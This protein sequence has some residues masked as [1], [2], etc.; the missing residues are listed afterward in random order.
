MNITRLERRVKLYSHLTIIYFLIAAIFLYFINGSVSIAYFIILIVTIIFGGHNC[1]NCEFYKNGCYNKYFV[2]T[3]KESEKEISSL[4]KYIGLL[5]GC[6][7]VFLPIIAL[8][9]LGMTG[10][11]TGWALIL[12]IM[13]VV[14]TISMSVVRSSIKKEYGEIKFCSKYH[15]LKKLNRI[16]EEV[17]IENKDK[18]PKINYAEINRCPACNVTNEDD[19]KF[20]F[21]CGVNLITFASSND[22]FLAFLLDGIFL[23]LM[24]FFVLLVLTIIFSDFNGVS[25]DLIL[26]TAFFLSILVVF[27]Y[28][29]ILGGPFNQ[30]Q[31]LGKMVSSMKVV[32]HSDKKTVTYKQSFIRTI[33]L[34]M[35]L[36]PYIV[37]GLLGTLKIK[38]SNENQ[39]IGDTVAKT[40][41][42]IEKLN[43]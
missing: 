11:L 6:I 5:L 3:K 43:R 18:K 35:D 20:C 38:R 22:R 13:I 40:I 37:P 19:A 1:C 17:R 7:L 14:V 34:F 24:C 21:E 31:T 16:S 9:Y 15:G 27:G 30:G 33:L 25:H 32:N 10:K 29:V 26:K 23:S 12:M 4:F 8:I 41:V 28:F 42:I 39:R 36:I 2:F